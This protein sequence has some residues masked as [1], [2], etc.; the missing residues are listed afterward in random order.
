MTP[1]PAQVAYLATQR[2]G[3]LATLNPRTGLLHNSPV[4]FWYDEESNAFVIGGRAM[5]ETRK[6]A[7]VEAT[8][9]ATL[10]VDDVVDPTTWVVRGVEIRGSAEALRGIT[11]G[12][13]TS[14]PRRS[15]SIRLASSAGDSTSPEASAPPAV[16][17]LAQLSHGRRAHCVRSGPVVVVGDQSR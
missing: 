9:V 11:H 3:R 10:V 7:N 14:A 8:G 17:A 15:A 1:N 12:P 4:T 6:F 13:A 16:R 2:L 5:G